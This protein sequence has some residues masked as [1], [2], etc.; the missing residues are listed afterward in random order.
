MK[1]NRIL[2]TAMAIVAFSILFLSCGKK[3]ELRIYSI[4]HDEETLALTELF[5]KKTGIPVSYLRATTGELVNRVIAEK[6]N[7]TVF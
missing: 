1:K 5:T 6:E 7:C 4:I 2:F 3:S